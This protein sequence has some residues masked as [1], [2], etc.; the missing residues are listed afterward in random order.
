[1]FRRILVPVDGG[2]ASSAGL[3]LA[4][5]LARESKARVRLV[6]LSQMML[7]APPAGGMPM[8][9]LYDDLRRSG[10]A[11]L[12][13]AEAAC[14]RARV[15]CDTSLDVAIANRPS[16]VIIDEARKWRA[17]LIVMGT[18]GRRGLARLA[19]GSE[20]ERVARSAPVPLLLA[21]ARG[22]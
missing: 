2:K 12:R 7:G 21:R 14:R 18:H 16:D 10:E 19:L 13:K 20:A 17:D 15:Q 8:S 6:H 3:A 4:V 1:M 11:I 9:A 5:R 22:R